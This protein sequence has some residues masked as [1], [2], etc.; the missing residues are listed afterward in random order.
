MWLVSFQ[1]Y[2][3]ILS[4]DLGISTFFSDVTLDITN[5]PLLMLTI[6][7]TINKGFFDLE[8]SLYFTIVGVIGFAG[9][10]VV[11]NL[12]KMA[13]S[14]GLTV[15]LFGSIYGITHRLFMTPP[16]VLTEQLKMAGLQSMIGIL[17]S[18]LFFPILSSFSDTYPSLAAFNI[19]MSSTCC[20]FASLIMHLAMDRPLSLQ[21]I[22]IA[23]I[24]VNMCHNAGSRNDIA[25][26]RHYS[27]CSSSSCRWGH[28]RYS[29]CFCG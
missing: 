2:F 20:I 25:N 6:A 22:F 24:A 27:E 10:Q 11:I 13:D 21:T 4:A 26:A 18:L 15:F 16:Y 7:F 29:E 3:L 28:H 17:F 14:G 5:L 19:F 1:F 23:S 9:N 8:F 12:L